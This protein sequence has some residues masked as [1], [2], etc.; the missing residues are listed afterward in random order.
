MKGYHTTEYRGEI[1]TEPLY[2]KDKEAWLG[3]GYYFW[4]EEE[5]ADFWGRKKNYETYDIY[6]ADLDTKKCLDTVYNEKEDKFF[7]ERVTEIIERLKRG[8][9]SVHIETVYRILK[10]QVLDKMGIQGVIYADET[11]MG[12]YGALKPF[13]YKKRIQIVIYDKTNISNFVILR[14]KIEKEY[15]RRY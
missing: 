6:S 13:L 10:Q 5:F 9:E 12:D 7:T 3:K 2:C 15:G 1:L 8:N 14:S 4:K 11:R